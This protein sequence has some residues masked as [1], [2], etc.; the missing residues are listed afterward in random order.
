MSKPKDPPALPTPEGYHP[1]HT[2]ATT[3]M[4]ATQL[5]GTKEVQGEITW[6][7]DSGL[8]AVFRG[9]GASAGVRV[10]LRRDG[11]YRPCKQPLGKEENRVLLGSAA[12]PAT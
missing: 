12:N 2:M 8:E 5:V 6:V 4:P 7:S 3:K 1:A 9:F 10:S 11:Y